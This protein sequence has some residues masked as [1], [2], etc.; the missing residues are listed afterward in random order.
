ME[1]GLTNKVAFVA[2]S[3]Q[4]LGKA[5]ALEMASYITGLSIAVDGGWIKN[6]L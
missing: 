4:G 2:A 3:G 6:I 5:V 1:L